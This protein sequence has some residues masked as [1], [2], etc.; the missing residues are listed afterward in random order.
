MDLLPTFSLYEID[1][2]NKVLG[3]CHLMPLGVFLKT[4]RSCVDFL[5]KIKTYE[6]CLIADE[7]IKYGLE[8]ERQIKSAL[9]VDFG[10][11]KFF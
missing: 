10:M 5:K 8:S 1:L 9:S 11:A 2:R 4:F 3:R 6:I 7:K